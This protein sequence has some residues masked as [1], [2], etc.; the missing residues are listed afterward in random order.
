MSEF[1][2]TRFRCGE[3]GE[4]H[5]FEDDAR[6][7][8]PPQVSKVFVCGECGD[9]H[10]DKAEAEACCADETHE[11]PPHHPIPTTAQLEALGQLRLIP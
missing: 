6:E 7:C 9:W 1:V 8:C 11:L 4:L 10:R 3:C 2:T 5:D